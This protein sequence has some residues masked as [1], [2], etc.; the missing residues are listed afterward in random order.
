MLFHRPVICDNS[1]RAAAL[2]TLKVATIYHK[3]TQT[4]ALRDEVPRL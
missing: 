4:E 2:R 3:D 1:E